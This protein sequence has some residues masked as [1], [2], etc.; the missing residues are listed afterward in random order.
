MSKQRKFTATV[1]EPPNRATAT[2]YGFAIHLEDL[3]SDPSF[4]THRLVIELQ[5]E[6]TVEQA[7][8]LARQLNRLGVS[9]TLK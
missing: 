8:E 3:E 1:K 6:T 4:G 7:D 5:P 9:V 2:A